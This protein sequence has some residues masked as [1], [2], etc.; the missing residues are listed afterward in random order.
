MK[1]NK[2]TNTLS[3]K[4]M[5]TKKNKKNISK[6]NIKNKS[7]KGGGMG[8]LAKKQ[9]Q[10]MTGDDTCDLSIPYLSTLEKTSYDTK[11]MLKKIEE[12]DLLKKENQ[13]FKNIFKVNLTYFCGRKTDTK[14][15]KFCSNLLNCVKE[16]R[17]FYEVLNDAFDLDISSSP[18]LK[19]LYK[20][21]LQINKSLTKE[22]FYK[23][24]KEQRI[25]AISNFLVRVLFK[26]INDFEKKF[27][28]NNKS[29]SDTIF[30]K[31]KFLDL[32]KDIN[33]RI[34]IKTIDVDE[35]K[36]QLMKKETAISD[37]YTSR[38]FSKDDLQSINENKDERKPTF[39][40]IV[41]GGLLTTLLLKLNLFGAPPN[42]GGS[43]S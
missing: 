11:K 33:L 38:V 40:F 35:L 31:E 14:Y 3:N 39:I 30:L 32:F 16:P 42:I 15:L 43:I 34:N 9:L 21:Q 18:K 28:P 13:E 26:S 5:K 8:T 2:K 27:Q 6:N 7:K 24:E 12:T 19:A 10:T 22:D 1:S 25:L 37:Y 4:N 17:L 23:E 29:P 36:E 41:I 20:K